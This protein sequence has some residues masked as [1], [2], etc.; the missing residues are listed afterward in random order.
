MYKLYKS[1]AAIVLDTSSNYSCSKIMK[2][3]NEYLLPV[4]GPITKEEHDNEERRYLRGNM[5]GEARRMDTV[6]PAGLRLTIL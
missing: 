1:K 4:F 3:F 6:L 5:V 2:D